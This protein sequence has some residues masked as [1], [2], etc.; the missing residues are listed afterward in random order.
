[1]KIAALIAAAGLS[2]RMG[3]F[4]PLMKIGGLSS[5][6]RIVATMKSA[7]AGIVT[8]VTGCR[9]E[10]LEKHLAGKDTVFLRNSAYES[11]EMFDSVRIGLEYLKD[12]CD[13]ILFSPVDTPLFTISTARR[14]TASGADLAVP[15]CSG[16]AGHPVLISAKA[17]ERILAFTGEGG[18]RGAMESTGIPIQ[19][20]ETDDPGVLLDADTPEDLNAL[21]ALHDRQMIRASV[22]VS[23]SRDTPFLTE[24]T[25]LLLSIIKE[26][27]SV[28]TA[29]QRTGISY[30]SGWQAIKRLEE[31]TGKRAVIRTRGGKD[32]GH[33]A[34]TGDGEQLLSLFML[35]REQVS[36]Q[37][38][39]IY[40]RVFRGFFEEEAE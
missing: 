21:I 24:S 3:S 25:A 2:S 18:L 30:S 13:L 12:K 19:R 14:L 33:S 4:K 32:G 35:Y 39:R 26:T 1:M 9:A 5:A 6:E 11:T 8:V 20:I 28:H 34:L 38:D 10:E 17:A 29:C 15:V 7:G 37:A 40:S 22:S 23:L 27:G 16:Q 31:Q 36:E